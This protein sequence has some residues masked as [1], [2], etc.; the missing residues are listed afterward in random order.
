[1][2]IKRS[3]IIIMITFFFTVVW[4]LQSSNYRDIPALRSAN[5]S[6]YDV[7]IIMNNSAFGYS[8]MQ[9]YT[10]FYTA[11]FLIFL[12]HL[13]LSENLATIIRGT[14]REKL[15]IRRVVKI[16]IA[17]FMFAFLHS[18]VN[19]LFTAI[20][21]DY[22]L[23]KEMNFTSICLFNTVGLFLFYTSVGLIY[24]LI[25]EISHSI[26]IS[27]FLTI[28]LISGLF[29]FEKLM[30]TQMW[31]PIKDLAIYNKMLEKEWTIVDLLYI[32]VRQIFV[33][34]FFYLIGSFVYKRKDFI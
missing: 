5:L 25:K 29:F 13:F 26:S 8:S 34:I 10:V 6:L 3:I 17:A 28:A 33:V 30:M 9:A 27:F 11:P 22:S 24:E 7:I 14:N 20:F 15:Y 12:N 2:K 1:M 18:G 19:L 21:F 16:I 23:L 31:G 4:F 32:Y